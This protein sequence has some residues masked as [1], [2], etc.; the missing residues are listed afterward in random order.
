MSGKG[1]RPRQFS[2]DKKTFDRN[3]DKI[4]KTNKKTIKKTK[5]SKAPEYGNN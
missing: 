1:S 5:S 4:F 3:W 2:V